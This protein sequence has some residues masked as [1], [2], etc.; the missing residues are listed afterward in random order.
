MSKIL[1]NDRLYLLLTFVLFVLTLLLNFYSKISYCSL[2]FTFL[3]FTVNI[4]SESQG[5]KKAIKS[6]ILCTSA[7]FA[8]AILYNMKYYIYGEPLTGLIFASLLSVFISSYIS[9]IFFLKRK[10]QHSFLTRNFKS[11]LSHAFID[12]LVMSIFFTSKFPMHRVLSIFYKETA[13][14]LV[15]SCL[16]HL[17]IL[18]TF[19]L[20]KQV[21]VSREYLSGLNITQLNN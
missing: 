10:L 18:T 4:I 17:F 12:G 8:F 13:Y 14:K 11:L 5:Y 19:Y 6:V 16:L 2:I 9:L 21:K 3:A 20:L 7:S 15:Y 1:N